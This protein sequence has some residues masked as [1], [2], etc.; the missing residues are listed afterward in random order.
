MNGLLRQTITSMIES[1][2]EVATLAAVQKDHIAQ[3][4]IELGSSRKAVNAYLDNI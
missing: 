2:E 4:A 1:D 3:G